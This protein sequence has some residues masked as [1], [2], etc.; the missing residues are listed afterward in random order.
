MRP[1]RQKAAHRDIVWI[2]WGQVWLSKRFLRYK[3][4]KLLEKPRED[5]ESYAQAAGGRAGSEGAGNGEES[6]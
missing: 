1:L 5:S 2:T 3:R 6:P 4:K